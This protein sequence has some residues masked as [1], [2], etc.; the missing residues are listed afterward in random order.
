MEE[1]ARTFEERLVG[2]G[3]D[4]FKIA[5]QRGGIVTELTLGGHRLLYLDRDTFN[6]PS[7]SVRGGIPILFPICG[8]LRDDRWETGGR[9]YGMKQHGFARVLPWQVVS[10]E[11]D[12]ITIELTSSEVTRTSYP[13]DFSIRYTYQVSAGH[14]HIE[15]AFENRSPQPMPFSSG[16]H[17]YFATLDKSALRFDI[18]ASVAAPNPY[19]DAHSFSGFD[20]SADV[21]D[22]RF[23]VRNAALSPDMPA[24]R[25]HF[26]DPTQ[27]RRITL[28]AHP[29]YRSF[30]FWTLRDKPFCCLEPWTA[31]GDALNTGDDVLEVK[32]GETRHLWFEIGCSALDG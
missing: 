3:P 22:L 8:P 16:F 1:T 27:A 14:L 19:G 30:V 31:R 29:D 9:E 25:A 5:P 11:A 10:Q 17:P 20:F 26:D 12:R 24:P 7:K 13:F 23:P 32:P 6:D 15:Q 18:P 2:G 4:A 28:S 21:I